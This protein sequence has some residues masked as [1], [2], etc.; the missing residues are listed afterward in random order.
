MDWLFRIIKRELSREIFRDGVKNSCKIMY[1]MIH[2]YREMQG[3][4]PFI[5]LDSPFRDTTK[6]DR[7]FSI[8]SFYGATDI[9]CPPYRDSFTSKKNSNAPWNETTGRR[10]KKNFFFEF[11][12]SNGTRG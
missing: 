1:S 7:L 4:R 2:D 9:D 6:I 5:L 8:K 11:E 10:G 3:C 12:N